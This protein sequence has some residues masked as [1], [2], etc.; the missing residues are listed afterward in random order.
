MRV[1]NFFDDDSEE[2]EAFLTVD[3]TTSDELD[4]VLRLQ[5]TTFFYRKTFSTLEIASLQNISSLRLSRQHT[6]N[7]HLVKLTDMT[8]R[9]MP[10]EN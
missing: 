2:T 5:R 10:K 7:S 1:T 8:N 4:K 6:I 9:S 3:V